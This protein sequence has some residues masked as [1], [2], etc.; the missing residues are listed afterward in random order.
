[1]TTP[2]AGRFGFLQQLWPDLA[3]FGRKAELV[4]GQE[5]EL[6]AIRLRGFTEAMVVKLA[7]H[8]SLSH[9]PNE[10]HFD[11]LVQLENA[12]LLDARLTSKFHAIRKLGNKA[13]HNRKVTDEQAAALLEDAWSL[14]CWFCRFMRPDL[15]WFTPPLQVAEGEKS[16]EPI[17]GTSTADRQPTVSGG[18]S[19]VLRF[20]DERVR[21]IHENVARAMALVDPRIRQLRTRI[22][23]HEAFNETLSDDQVACLDLLQTFL[24]DREQRVFL[25]KGYAGTGK[26]FLVKGITEFLAAQGRAFRLAAPTGRAAKIISEK[27][28][29]DARTA[30]SQIYDFG[31]LREFAQEDDELGSETFKF[32]AEIAS[33]QD[34]ANTV[35]IV[36]EASLLSDVYS[37]SEF[38]RSG[39]GYLLHDLISYIGFDHGETDRKIILVG[40]PAQLPP[41][42]MSTSP[43]L[44]AKYL[45]QTFGLKPVEYELKQVLRQKAESGVMR[46]VMPLRK[47]LSA[48]S[49][50]SLTFSFDDDV[51]RLCADDVL[52][53]YM[54]SRARAGL[55][56]PIIITRSNG[57]AA[58]FNRSIRDEI[59]PGREFVVPGDRL[60]ITANAI[61]DGTFLANGEFVEVVDAEAAVER[62]VVTLRQRNKESGDVEVL[63]V[64]LVF[65]DIRLAVASLESSEAVFAT[66]ILDD[67]LHDG[68]AGLDAAQQRALYVD[69]LKRHPDL[70]KGSDRE[71]ISQILRRDPYF[72]ALRVRFG[73]AVTCHKAQGGE[74]EY[75][76]V[77][78][79]SGQNPRTADYFRWLYTAMTRS[80]SKLYLVDPPEIRLKEVGMPAQVADG[81]DQTASPLDAFRISV[82][83][84][85]RQAIEGTGIEIDDV[86][87]HQYQEA[88]Y[89][90]RDINTARVNISYNDRF[91]ITA[92]AVPPGGLLN[93][94]L[95]V[96]LK[97]LIGQVVGLVAHGAGGM[98]NLG[99]AVPSRPFLTAFHDRL[100]PL[101]EAKKITVANLKEQ[102][103]S[104][105]YTFA[106]EMESAVVDIYYDGKER[107]TTCMPTAG[108]RFNIAGGKLLP[109]V[110]E[111]LT[112]EVM[113]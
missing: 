67:H 60:I 10:A 103:W 97:P 59:F 84:R 34:Q 28:G 24:S 110:L 65:R 102:A 62:R 71:R 37:E 26:T 70:K 95:G 46:N 108:K 52:P 11:R 57:E 35:Y 72:N 74:W 47:S 4:E 23:L 111:I 17:A 51:Q 113:P 100:L 31:A 6:V 12:D 82:L 7:R 5:P 98:D 50:S 94:Q 61:V 32:Y 44:D 18:Q 27:T 38:F 109:E 29:R 105:R 36:D 64:T 54:A 21:R 92:V 40:D 89:F 81:V 77:S 42:G 39:T 15:E 96:L 86:A 112:R 53:L 69:F 66:K 20:P 14:A 8:L 101:L 30:H 48:G 49:F 76:F 99:S 9:D 73:Y 45:R 2:D 63:D 41:V 55:V 107:L 33:N 13:A 22:T 58:S 80:S 78:C 1:M 87:H 83:R 79:P 75:V 19:N 88:F 91:A 106:R 85:M 16:Q 56:A 3:D 43:A 93:D 104:Q 68:R 90:R 25:L